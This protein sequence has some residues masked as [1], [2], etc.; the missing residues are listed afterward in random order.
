MWTENTFFTSNKNIFS[1]TCLST[2]RRT[3]VF[4]NILSENRPLELII[5]AIRMRDVSEKES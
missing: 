3:N 4:S 2:F 5:E 1:N